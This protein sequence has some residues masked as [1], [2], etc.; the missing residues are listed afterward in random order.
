MPK[1]VIQAIQLQP[2]LDPIVDGLAAGSTRFVL[3]HQAGLSKL[4]L[5]VGSPSVIELPTGYIIALGVSTE[6]IRGLR[7]DCDEL[8]RRLSS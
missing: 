6:Q 5:A 3:V 7:D 4:T 8:L 2:E 1:R